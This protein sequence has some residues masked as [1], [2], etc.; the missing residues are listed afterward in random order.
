LVGRTD[1]QLAP[2]ID[3]LVSA[4]VLEV[5]GTAGAHHYKITQAGV[6]FL[7]YIKANYPNDWDKRYY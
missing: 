5:S 1:Y 7:S 3:F 6:E 4:G 2:F